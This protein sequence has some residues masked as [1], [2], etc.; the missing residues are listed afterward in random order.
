MLCCYFVY[1]WV[2]FSLR[3][4]VFLLP[5]FFA[6]TMYK[7]FKLLTF[8][9]WLFF[10][11]KKE[12]FDWKKTHS[13]KYVDRCALK[14]SQNFIVNFF[15][16]S[17]NIIFMKWFILQ[18]LNMWWV[19]HIIRLIAFSLFCIHLWCIYE[20]YDIELKQIMEVGHKR[21]RG[22]IHTYK[23]VHGTTTSCSL[24][25]ILSCQHHCVWLL[26]CEKL[27]G[28][29]HKLSVSMHKTIINLYS[30]TSWG[31]HIFSV[32]ETCVLCVCF[33]VLLMMCVCYIITSLL[34]F[35]IEFLVLFFE[36]RFLF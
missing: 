16:G 10:K 14:R 29:H 11:K 4:T 28:Q 3:T 20:E 19:R 33:F 5:I 35:R 24:Q 26:E 15:F 18:E 8:F 22:Y 2:F 13:N 32:W 1:T 27:W 17:R 36:K 21:G 31:H 12:K 25:H 23:Q 30:I 9:L 7:R 34:Q 6:V